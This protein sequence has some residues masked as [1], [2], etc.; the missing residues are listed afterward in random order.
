MSKWLFKW[1]K[2][3][4][5]FWKKRRKYIRADNELDARIKFFLWLSPDAEDYLLQKYSCMS[6]I[7][8]YSKVST[9]DIKYFM[10]RFVELGLI[11]MITNVSIKE[12]V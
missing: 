9:D 5:G 3:V 6:I 11:G 1:K 2:K 4:N 8:V 10:S 12:L 7:D